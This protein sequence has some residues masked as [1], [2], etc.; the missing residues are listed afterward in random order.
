MKTDKRVLVCGGGPVGLFCALLLG[1]EG[2]PVRLFDMNDELQPDP[3]AATTHPATLEVLGQAG[4]LE[5]MERVGLVAPVF[6]FWDRPTGR[7]VAEFD[8]GLLK[9]DTLYPYVIQCEQFKTA[10]IMLDRLR[11]LPNVQ[12][13]FGHEAVAVEQSGE[14][15]TVTVRSKNG[16]SR[17]SGAYLIGADGGRSIVRK[18]SDISFEGFTWAER[19]LVLTTPFDFLEHRGYCYRSYFADPDEWCNCF[20]VAADGRP[21]L[22]RTVFPTDPQ[23][24]EA[25]LMSD[26]AVQAQLQKFFPNP[27]SYQIVHRNLYTT[28]QR[29]AA[30]FR[31]GRVLLAGDSAHVNNSIGG[32]GLNGGLQDAANLSEKLIRVMKGGE[33]DRLLDLYSL[34]RRTVSVEFVQEQSIANKKRLEAREPEQRRQNFEELSRSAADPIRAREFLLR[35]SMIAMQRRAADIT[36]DQAA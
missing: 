14:E 6:Q 28:H 20:K 19:F 8:H 13:R 10:R 4:L 26:D 18:Q 3:R 29:V 16:K 15:V 31:K 32:M 17:H 22:W 34:Q 24:S 7:L 30:T 11:D 27:E 36:L 5:E 9:Q 33:S 12:V 25:D 2:I 1:R 23:A 21:G 35:S